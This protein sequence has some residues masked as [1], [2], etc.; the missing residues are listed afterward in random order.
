MEKLTV[1]CGYSARINK[2]D[3]I[4]EMDSHRVR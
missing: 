1:K 4:Q 2:K 3:E